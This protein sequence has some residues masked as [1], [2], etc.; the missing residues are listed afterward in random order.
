MSKKRAFVLI[1]NIFVII[2]LSTGF[3][4]LITLLGN[5]SSSLAS[6]KDELCAVLL[7][8]EKMEHLLHNGYSAIT[9]ETITSVSG[10]TGFSTE[11]NVIQIDGSDLSTEVIWGSS[12]Y[13]K[14]IVSVIHEGLRTIE[15]CTIKT[16]Y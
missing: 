14:I 16:D 2:I 13:R 15:L 9:D 12:N 1:E 11:V 10:F 3:I 7:A 4:S 6:V 8:Q 5:E